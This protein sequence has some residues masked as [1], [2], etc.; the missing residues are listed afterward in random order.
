MEP[1]YLKLVTVGCGSQLM[2]INS[3]LGALITSPRSAAAS[4]VLVSWDWVRDIKDSRIEGDVISEVQ[5]IQHFSGIS[6]LL[7]RNGY[8]SRVRSRCLTQK[9]VNKN[10]K[11]ERSQNITLKNAC[12]YIKG[13]GDASIHY[14]STAGI[15]VKNLYGIDCSFGDAVVYSVVSFDPYCLTSARFIN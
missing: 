13:I 3:V 15:A 4:A 10:N 8:H 12:C 2:V 1:K 7:A 11:E 5:V 9:V 6:S 14:Y